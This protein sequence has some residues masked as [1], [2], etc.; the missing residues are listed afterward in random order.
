MNESLLAQIRERLSISTLS[1]KGV[2]GGSINETYRLETPDGRL[3]CKV[4]SSS[5]FPGL[6]ALEKSGLEELAKQKLIRTPGVI[7]CFEWNSYQVLLLEWISEG[8]R[9]DKFWNSFGTQLAAL[10]K[11]TRDKYGAHENNYMGSVPQDNSSSTNWPDFLEKQRL[12]PM[13]YLCSDK[14]LLTKNHREQFHKIIK[15]L[16]EIF[17]SSHCPSLQHG[18][19]WSGN[20]MCDENSQP[21]LIDP[22]VYYGH[23]SVDL[24]MTTLFGGFHSLFYDSYHYI[25]PFPSNYREQWKVCNLYPLL[26]HLYL[27]GSGYLRQIES[28]LNEFD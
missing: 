6:F 8:H 24:A 22:A 13:M 7:D 21:V 12:I 15:H 16:P 18:D 27:F 9:S 2:G 11:I 3:F 23:P 26:I 14:K 25:S 28:I 1:A 4:N 10:H 5:A 20:F 17:E 19:L